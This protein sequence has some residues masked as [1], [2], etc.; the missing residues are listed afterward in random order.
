MN[1]VQY[2]GTGRRKSSVARTILTSGSGIIKIN[3][4]DFHNYILSAENRFEILKPL[5]LIDKL[6]QYNIIVS[7]NGGGITS[8]AGAIRLGIAR[9]LLKAEPHSRSILKKAGFLTRDSRVVERKKPGHRKSRA[10]P[11]FSK[12]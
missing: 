2:F 1:V 4:R 7:V 9:S 10:R 5:K 3:K 8:Q 11:Q 12:R 6:E